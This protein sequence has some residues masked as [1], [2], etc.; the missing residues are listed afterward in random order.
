[1][2]EAAAQGRAVQL[3]KLIENGASVN[4][5]AVNSI[6]PLHEACIKGQTQCVKLLL[7]AGAH[8]RMFSILQGRP[9]ESVSASVV[10]ISVVVNRSMLVTL[11]AA[12]RCVMPV[13]P[14]AWSV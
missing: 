4:I 5:V 6:T 9:H 12:L 14:V 10:Y 2:H 1:M 3:Q 13:L 7:D 11:T 8:V